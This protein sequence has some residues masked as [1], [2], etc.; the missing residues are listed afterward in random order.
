MQHSVGLSEPYFSDLEGRPSSFCNQYLVSSAKVS[1]QPSAFPANLRHVGVPSAPSHH[2]CEPTARDPHRR[3]RISPATIE[4]S[5]GS[6]RDVAG[7]DP[8]HWPRAFVMVAVGRARTASAP[9][10]PQRSS[11]VVPRAPIEGGPAMASAVRERWPPVGATPQSLPQGP[12]HCVGRP[13]AVAAGHSDAAAPPPTGHTAQQRSAP[14][15][16]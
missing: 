2:S 9:L 4:A 6:L 3:P 1:T 5:S 12:G 13:R 10:P 16:E 7:V 11:G 15:P 14:S 8:R